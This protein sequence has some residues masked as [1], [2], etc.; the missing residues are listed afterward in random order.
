M[1]GFSGFLELGSD[2]AD[3]RVTAIGLGRKVIHADVDASFLNY[4]QYVDE[5]QHPG[6]MFRILP[7]VAREDHFPFFAQSR[8]DHFELV[9]GEALAFIHDGYRID[10][11]SLD[12]RRGNRFDFP[13]EFQFL[14]Y[15]SR[16]SY[17]RGHL[18][19]DPGIAGEEAKTRPASFQRGADQVEI[20]VESPI[21]GIDGPG[22][23]GVRFPASRLAHEHRN[24]PL[25]NHPPRLFLVFR[26]R[27]VDGIPTRRGLVDGGALILHAWSAF[28]CHFGAF[29]E[30]V[31]HGERVP[32]Y[33]KARRKRLISL[34]RAHSDPRT[35][36]TAGRCDGRFR[37]RGGSYFDGT[38]MYQ[39][40]EF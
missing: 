11:N 3:K 38:T 10:G 14:Q 35:T 29:V 40:H 27:A 36:E 7:R 16:G 2:L 37:F 23:G 39:E 34:N 19:F 22:Y 8:C 12:E 18:S 28:L 21:D 6:G 32:L 1:Q 30:G 17:P 33:R 31:E 4:R 13:L 24:G 15:T 9:E 25:V 20:L 5:W 26:Q